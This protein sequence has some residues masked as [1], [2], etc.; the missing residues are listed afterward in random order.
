MG[1]SSP[2]PPPAPDPAATAAAQAAANKEAAQATA[3]LNMLDVNSPYGTVRY[4]PTNDTQDGITRYQQTISLT[5]DQQKQLDASNTL[6]LSLTNLANAQTGR[7]ATATNTPLDFSTLPAAPTADDVA[8]Q[9]VE[10]ALYQRATSRLDPQFQQDQQRLE[11]QLVNQGFARGSDAYNKA[12]DQFG[13]TRND[14]YEQAREAAVADA[15]QE[16]SRLFGLQTAARQNALN[17][18]L[19]Q[20]ELPINEVATLLG[21]S[22]GVQAPQFAQPASANVAPADITGPTALQYQGQLNAYNQ[23]QA[24][25]NALMGG[26]FGL[27]GSLGLGALMSPWM[28]KFLSDKNVKEDKRKVDT[29]AVLRGLKKMPVSTWR[30]IGEEERHMGPMAQDFAKQF[31]GDGHTIDVPSAFGVSFAAIKALADK[32]DSLKGKGR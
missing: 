30:Y 10:D 27:G 24:S 23:Q 8:R 15:G 26:L 6:G 12:L 25:N 3:R 13:R 11:T 9:R 21:T 1:K 17:E 32:V 20:R 22:P 14:A 31:G 7:V 29:A 18:A 28:G 16:Q 4:T 5:P 19:T 2:S